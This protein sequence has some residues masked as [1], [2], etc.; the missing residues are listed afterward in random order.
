MNAKGFQERF[1][2]FVQPTGDE[3]R[4]G[5]ARRAGKKPKP[6]WPPPE[7]TLPSLDVLERLSRPETQHEQKSGPGDT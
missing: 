1:G 5:R 4:A 2:W 7:L 6:D 3:R